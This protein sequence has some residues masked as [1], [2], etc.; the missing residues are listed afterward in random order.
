MREYKEGEKKEMARPRKALKFADVL[1][2]LG[3]ADL[4]VLKTEVAVETRHKERE[5][6]RTKS[7]QESRKMRDRIKIGQ[8]IS[9]HQSGPNGQLIKAEVIGIFANKVQVEVG[10]RK[11][12]VALTRVTA[13]G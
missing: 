11:R 8:T 7:E 3:I 5:E 2:P 12:S 9:F 13:V 1:G 4:K 6:L 10:G